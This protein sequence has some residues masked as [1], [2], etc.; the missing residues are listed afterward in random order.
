[1]AFYVV[2]HKVNDFSGWKK[3][4][5]EFESTRKQYGVKEHYALQSEVDPNHVMV[6]GEGELEAIQKF[7]NSEDLKSGM[8]G[9]GIAS[10]PEIFVGENIK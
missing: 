1:M 3:V 5:D 2:N 6:V 9:A 4:Y 7:L 10:L 8:E